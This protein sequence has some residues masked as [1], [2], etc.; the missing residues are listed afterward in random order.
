MPLTTN[1]LPLAAMVKESTKTLHQEVENLL[2]P[3]ISFIKNCND[4]A[5]V[6]KMFYGYFL[7]IQKRIEA[8]SKTENL[9]A[10]GKH[11]PFYFHAWPQT[12]KATCRPC[13][14]ETLEVAEGLR[15]FLIES[16]LNKKY[17]G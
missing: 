1:V 17:V 5:V 10:I 2:F 7:P 13:K 16:M 11:L 4:Y 8:Y 12:K 15:N 6:L 9:K 14:Q 3:K